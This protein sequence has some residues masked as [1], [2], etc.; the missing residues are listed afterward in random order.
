MKFIV[1]S[2][3]RPSVLGTRRSFPSREL[4]RNTS[5][6]ILFGKCLK[7]LETMTRWIM[8]VAK[9]EETNVSSGFLVERVIVI[10]HNR[11][12]SR[13]RCAV[14]RDCNATITGHLRASGCL[15]F[16]LNAPDE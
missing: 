2:C 4:Q 3:K 5:I 6:R 14:I 9:L 7:H 10:D 12:P 8:I 16:C 1:T 11:D 15:P 13:S